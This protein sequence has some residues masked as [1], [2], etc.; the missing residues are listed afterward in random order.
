MFKTA[1]ACPGA[2]A[3]GSAPTLPVPGLPTAHQHAGEQPCSSLAFL[4]HP[5]PRRL[6]R[7][8]PKDSASQGPTPRPSPS[9]ASEGP[10]TGHSILAGSSFFT[11]A[12]KF[13][14]CLQSFNL[15]RMNGSGLLAS[16]PALGG[17]SIA[18]EPGG[19]GIISRQPNASRRWSPGQ[20]TLGCTHHGKLV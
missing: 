20:L 16:L 18:A 4:G 15:L 19:R 10:D 12:C 11:S 9:A 7:R 2:A 3:C 13:Q 5:W 14:R 8:L 17:C 1:A 6:E